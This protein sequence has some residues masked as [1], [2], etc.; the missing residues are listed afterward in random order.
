MAQVEQE[1]S[2]CLRRGQYAHGYCRI[3]SDLQTMANQAVNPLVASD[4]V[5]ARNTGKGHFYTYEILP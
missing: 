1:I 3:S 5:L 2:G 4:M